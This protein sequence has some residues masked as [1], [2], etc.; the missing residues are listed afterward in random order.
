[1]ETKEITAASFNEFLSEHKLMGTRCTCGG[2]V[3]LPPRAYCP[4]CAKQE[5][6]WIEFGGKGTLLTYTVIYFG[7]TA[8]INAGFDRKNPYCEG[9]VELAEGPRISALITG[10]D[11]LHPDSIIPGSPVM[12]DIQDLGPEGARKP[13]VAF[14]VVEE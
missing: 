3:Y 4:K 13:M 10:V 14:R 7:P 11:V 2:E 8:M 6:E 5:M 9:I 1:M 12:I